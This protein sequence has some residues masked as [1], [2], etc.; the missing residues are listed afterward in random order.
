VRTRIKSSNES[1]IF[2]LSSYILRPFYKADI[3]SRAGGRQ[4]KHVGEDSGHID[5]STDWIR[6]NLYLQAT[7]PAR[8]GGRTVSAS[9]G[10]C[11][12]WRPAAHRGDPP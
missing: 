3:Y 6:L 2:L 8:V 11:G 5:N 1:R 12:P 10:R 9:R 4:G 7:L